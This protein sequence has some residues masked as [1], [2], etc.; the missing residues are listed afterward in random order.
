MAIHFKSNKSLFAMLTGCFIGVII[1]IAFTA[2]ATDGTTTNG[3]SYKGISTENGRTT[4]QGPA[5]D[6]G[7]D[8][9]QVKPRAKESAGIRRTPVV[10]AVEKVAPAV[11]SITTTIPTSGG[12]GFRYRQQPQENSA[13]GSGVVIQSDG[14]VL[15]NAH[16]IEGASSITVT[17]VNGTEYKGE[18]IGIAEDI[19]LAVLRL[20]DA[21]GLTAVPIGKSENLMLGE[22]TIAIG[23]PFGLGHT[24]TTGVISSISRAIETDSRVYQDFIQTD[25]SIN[26]GNSG[27]PLLDIQGQLIGVNTAIRADAEGIGFAIPVDR[28]M[29]VARD[30]LNYGAVQ[31]PWLGVDLEDVI[32]QGG[33]SNT[34]APRIVRV[35]PASSAHAQ[36]V[37]VG[38]VIISVEGRNI[39][40]RSDLNA[41]LGGVKSGHRVSLVLER[42]G[43]KITKT[44]VSQGM[45]QSVA[46]RSINTIIGIS[47]STPP[48]EYRQW[49]GLVVTDVTP[50]GSFSKAG[51]REGDNIMSVNGKTTNTTEELEDAISSAK[52]GHRPLALFTIRRRDVV[53]HIELSI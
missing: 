39:Q 23:N 7:N 12:F 17:F 35:H 48:D 16:V 47:I 53:G 8:S 31:L 4:P 22:P 49:G 26:P 34:T 13:D 37:R 25:A 24:V 18:V 11:V 51:L 38:D 43:T 2:T 21:S 41:Y 30:L 20:T 3:E 45:P 14:V 46:K 36:G 52:S 1:A 19:D 32:I 40:G 50:N 15:T 6:D 29:K 44:L 28:A 5:S 9:E 27:G 10:V 33:R 42:D